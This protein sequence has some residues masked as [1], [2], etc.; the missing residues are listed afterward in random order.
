MSKNIKCDL[1]KAG[2]NNWSRYSGRYVTLNIVFGF[3]RSN[4]LITS[5]DGED[6][7]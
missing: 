4:D 1:A 7:S 3:A 6:L 5:E 2:W